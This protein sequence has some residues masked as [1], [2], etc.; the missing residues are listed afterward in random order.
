[1][2]ITI[3]VFAEE[4]SSEAATPM[5][6]NLPVNCLRRETTA[7]SCS[8][9]HT[10]IAVAAATEIRSALPGPVNGSKSSPVQKGMMKMLAYLVSNPGEGFITRCDYRIKMVPFQGIVE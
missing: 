1:M 6:E 8:N 5:R 3:E 2:T 7:S 4:T 9:F 10:T